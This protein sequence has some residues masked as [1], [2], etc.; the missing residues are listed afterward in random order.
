MPYESDAALA[1]DVRRFET[2]AFTPAEFTHARHV[3]VGLW[4]AAHA[5]YPEALARM[6]AGLR[7]FLDAHGVADAYH[8]TLTVFWMRLLAHV[9]ADEAP[10][11]LYERVNVALDRFG[12]M[13][14]VLAH[15]RRE[16]AFSDEAKA[17]WVEPDLRPL[18]F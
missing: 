3:A 16:T 17:A 4:Y 6:R 8:E 11:P 5:P 15:Y 18:P 12:S 10:R 13:A 14:P 9:A 2:A 7:R 1:D